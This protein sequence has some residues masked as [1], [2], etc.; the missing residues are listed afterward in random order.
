MLA[1]RENAIGSAP[2]RITMNDAG[3][4]SGGYRLLPFTSPRRWCAAASI[5]YFSPRRAGLYGA[6]DAS[7]AAC[8]LS[9]EAR[10]LN[11]RQAEYGSIG[12]QREASILCASLH[13]GQPSSFR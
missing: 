3:C 12:F 1:L 4:V 6:R 11:R 2:M 5:L 8:E 10:H 9:D 7:F 13:A